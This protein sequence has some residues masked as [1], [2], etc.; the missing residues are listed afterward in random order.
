M[1]SLF[2]RFGREAS[3][4]RK[5]GEKAIRYKRLAWG[6]MDKG[7]TDMNTWN[8]HEVVSMGLWFL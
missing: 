1:K 6:A 8:G 5:N 7:L 3:R 2:E 4:Q